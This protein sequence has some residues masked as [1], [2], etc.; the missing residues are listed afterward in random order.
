MTALTPAQA[1]ILRATLGLGAFGRTPKS[2]WMPP[3]IGEQHHEA[4]A[5]LVAA[6][7]MANAG[8]FYQATPAGKV[9]AVKNQP[10]DE[11]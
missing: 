8:T 3:E 1:A 10:K 6:G 2:N 9:A 5:E 11:R 4:L 7:L